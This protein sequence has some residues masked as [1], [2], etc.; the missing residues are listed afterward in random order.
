MQQCIKMT[1]AALQ[2]L[3]ILAYLAIGLLSVT[4]PI[5]A[6]CVTYLKQ[7]KYASEKERKR[8]MEKAKDEIIKLTNEMST[9]TKGSGR[10]RE[11]QEKISYWTQ[12]SE[13][14]E[15]RPYLLSARGAVLVPIL[16]LSGALSFACIGIYCYYEG[17]EPGVFIFVV[18]NLFFSCL[19]MI[20]LYQTICTVEHAALRGAVEVEL[21]SK[22]KE[23]GNRTHEV[24][25]AKEVDITIGIRSPDMDLEMA[26]FFVF[27]PSEI[28]VKAVSRGSVGLQ[29][30]TAS[31][32]NYTLVLYSAEFAPKIFFE[33]VTCRILAERV[34]EYKIPIKVSAKGIEE[35]TSELTLKVVQ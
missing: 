22:F 20:E 15:Q 27:F 21:I 7:E 23:T 2:I 18:G 33:S 10:F 3:L 31:F 12:E 11:L 29:P 9:E 16:L 1:E 5:Y 6:L 28:E 34:G 25:I 13:R 35:S 30:E 32:P 14:L 19:A 8:S 4:F 17:Y 26:N 24:K